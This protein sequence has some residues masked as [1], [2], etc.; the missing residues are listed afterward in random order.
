LF[1]YAGYPRAVS[2]LNLPLIPAHLPATFA[3]RGVAVP[4]TL[5]MLAGA[6]VRLAKNGVPEFMLP[7]PSGSRGVYIVFWPGVRQLCRPTVYDTLLQ[8]RILNLPLIDPAGIRLAARQVAAEGYAGHDAMRAA[9][10]VAAEERTG[11]DKAS[12]LLLAALAEQVLQSQAQQPT[13]SS[14]RAQLE[15]LRKQAILQTVTRLGCSPEDA[16]RGLTALARA[17]AP[18]GV[19]AD[20]ETAR[21]AA[22]LVR[23]TR[24]RGAVSAWVEPNQEDWAMGL[25]QDIARSVQVTIACG[26]LLLRVTRALTA[27]MVALLRAW[28]AAPAAVLRQIERLDWLLDGWEPLSLLWDAAQRSGFRR[29]ALLEMAQLVPILPREIRQ[30]VELPL[31][32]TALQPACRVISMDDGWRSGGAVFALIARNERLRAQSA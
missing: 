24:L 4:F 31:D 3:D 27:D 14:T 30:W 23:L 13:A 2:D 32:H 22:L 19:A 18:V 5:P 6:R 10:A 29:G 11:A 17:F 8:E 1:T 15:P 26:E 12:L 16:A 28:L 20:D 9:A 7:N 25:A 21:L